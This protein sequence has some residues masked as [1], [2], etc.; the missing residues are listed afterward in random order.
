MLIRQLEYFV[1][2]A[3]VK[4]FAKAA[5]ICCITQ[6]ALSTAIRNLEAELGIPVMKRGRRYEG[7]TPEGEHILQY[8]NQILAS[9]RGMK[10]VAAIT[11]NPNKLRIG[12]IPTAMHVV[13]L[14]TDSFLSS[15]IDIREH[16]KTMSMQKIIA[17]LNQHEID[18]GIGYVNESPGSGM[19]C[20]PIFK[21]NFVLLARKDSEVARQTSIS[22]GEA[23]RLPLC[24]L[25][26]ELRSRQQINAAF[27]QADA[28]PRIVLETNSPA[29]L[30]NHVL[31]AGLYS[32]VPHCLGV[33]RI[34][35]SLDEV[36]LIDLV[37]TMYDVVGLIVPDKE[38]NSPLIKAA[39]EYIESLR[40]EKTLT[41]LDGSQDDKPA[42]GN[43]NF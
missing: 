33:L 1:T 20:L 25:T 3:K 9:W 35:P 14:L 39:W 2:L 22:W 32:I 23:A 17:S 37:P 27:E 4:H 15:N 29:T 11:K 16:V 21:E 13:A 24:L 43:G 36:A 31:S 26:D 5:E 6:P 28:K 7:L 12:V 19:K 41:L 8:A 18:M 40:D 30:Y 42:G 38:M 10:Q 34:L